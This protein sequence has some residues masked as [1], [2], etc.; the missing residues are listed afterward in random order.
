MTKIHLAQI[1]PTIGDLEA[2]TNQI[3][4]LIRSIGSGLILFPELALTGYPPGDLLYQTSFLDQVDHCSRQIQQA[5]EGIAVILGLPRRTEEG[6]KNS[7][8]IFENG[9]V[10]GYHDK[11]LLPN[12]DVFEESRYFVK[13][14]SASC[15]QVAGKKV[16]VT[17][18]EDIWQ[19]GGFAP[20][21]AYTQDPVRELKDSGCELLVNLSSSPHSDGKRAT[22]RQVARD[23]STFLGCPVALCNQV[24]AND[25]L[26]FDGHSLYISSSQCVELKGFER[27]IASVSEPGSTLPAIDE[28]ADR[29]SALSMGVSEYFSKQGFGSALLGLSGGIDSALVACIAVHAFGKE[30]VKAVAMPSRYSSE[31]SLVDARRLA[32]NLGI[33][34][35]EIPIES[36]FVSLLETL[37]PH[38]AGKPANIT[39]ENLQARIRGVIL[40]ALANKHGG[41]VL[42]TGNKSEAAM[43]YATL[44]GDMC[45]SISPIGD[46]LKTEVYELA[47]WI[48]RN[49]E[50]IPEAILQKA[51]S[52]ELAPNQTDQD[53]LPPYEVIDTVL[54]HYFDQKAL[55]PGIDF[56]VAEEI[57][58]RLHRF[59]FK[60]RQAPF[61]LRVSSKAFS[62]GWHWPIVEKWSSHP[63]LSRQS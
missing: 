13:G 41:L 20:L 43:G 30:H 35:L 38:F 46:V 16:A 53:S 4:E 55:P 51:P 1:N 23:I 32:A 47:Q 54:A 15:F 3:I 10:I 36:P 29:F 42:A 7:A 60:R 6:L 48:N 14:E 40:M 61:A 59:E 24:G 56:G 9:E 17:I 57:L 21:G 26:L 50:V 62:C 37:E 19:H 25:A 11:C 8:A 33:E 18:C 22:R 27:H 58:R 34:L 31:G 2:N 44:Y 5:S 52:A 63:E 45:G 49:G 28:L 39:E 12:Y